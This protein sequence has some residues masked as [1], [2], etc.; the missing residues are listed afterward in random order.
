VARLSGMG[1]DVEMPS[2]WDARI[3]A[4]APGETGPALDSGAPSGATHAVVHAGNFPLP[5]ARGDF[6]SGAVEVMR[7]GDVLVVLF[8]YGPESAGTPLFAAPGPP[9]ALTADRFSPSALQR[10][11]PGQMGT[12]VFFSTANRAFCLYVVLATRARPDRLVGLVNPVLA[13]LR[14]AAS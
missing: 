2:G 12:Q 6:G 7:S 9:Q 10:V 8:E 13:S 4:R 11:I 5:T 14:I 1:I 3:Y